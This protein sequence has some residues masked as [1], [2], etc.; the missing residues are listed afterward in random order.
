MYQAGGCLCESAALGK[1]ICSVAL[2]ELALAASAGGLEHYD[3]LSSVPQLSR[4]CA[5]VSGL[6]TNCR[7][8]NRLLLVCA[9]R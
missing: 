7:T 5:G 1:H 2:S 3:K 4:L 6:M 8:E 9:W